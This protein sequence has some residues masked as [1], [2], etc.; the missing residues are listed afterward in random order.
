MRTRYNTSYVTQTIKDRDV[1]YRVN[2]EYLPADPGVRYYRDGSGCP[3]APAELNVLDAEA[4]SIVC[5]D[6]VKID[7]QW[8]V[9]R[10][11]AAVVDNP[12]FS[13]DTLAE[14]LATLEGADD[15]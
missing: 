2:F 5:W 8:L 12:E 6:G 7:R 11:W 1:Y 9:A 14:M 13:E 15:W 3:P 10:G 4:V